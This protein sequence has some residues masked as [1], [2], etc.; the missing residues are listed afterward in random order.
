M[1]TLT[2][3]K[4][5]TVSANEETYLTWDEMNVTTFGSMKE[6]EVDVNNICNDRDDLFRVVFSKSKANVS[7]II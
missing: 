1:E 3:T 4:K 2:S 6:I 5:C 7:Q